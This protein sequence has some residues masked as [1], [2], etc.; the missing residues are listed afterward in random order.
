MRSTEGSTEGS[1][2]GPLDFG[3]SPVS[4]EIQWTLSGP[5]SGPQSETAS[6][7]RHPCCEQTRDARPATNPR[8]ATRDSRQRMT[9]DKNRD[10]A[11]R[12]PRP[13]QEELDANPDRQQSLGDVELDGSVDVVEGMLESEV[14]VFENP[15]ADARVDL[16][17]VPPD[18]RCRKGGKSAE[19]V[20]QVTAAQCRLNERHRPDAGCDLIAQLQLIAG[21]V[22]SGQRL[23]DAIADPGEAA[24]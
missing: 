4:A 1:T 19:V 6:L 11:T 12:N 22:Q 23:P 8:R 9:R 15:D 13:K 7:R 17:P 16:G 20:H 10:S 24:P 18:A 21:A 2:W 3:D 14:V 5:H